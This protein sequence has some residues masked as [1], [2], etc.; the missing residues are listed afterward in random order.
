M[1]NDVVIGNDGKPFA[2]EEGRGIRFSKIEGSTMGT[3][4]QEGRS[5]LASTALLLGELS[6][7][8]TGATTAGLLAPNKPLTQ[9]KKPVSAGFA[10][11]EAAGAVFVATGAVEVAVATGRGA[12]AGAGA[13]GKTPLIIGTCLLVGS[14]ERRVTAVGS[15]ISS[16]IL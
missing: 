9:A 12:A 2:Y 14:C 7:M 6:S 8:A 5:R 1:S 4:A 16:A 15:S 13:S 3:V 10:V 11:L